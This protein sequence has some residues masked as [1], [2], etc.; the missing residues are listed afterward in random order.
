MRDAV[1]L[2]KQDELHGRILYRRPPG[3]RTADK[4][5]ESFV[6]NALRSDA[7]SGPPDPAL[8]RLVRD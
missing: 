3:S 6:V 4:D 8:I 5:P 1:A 2:T 7:E